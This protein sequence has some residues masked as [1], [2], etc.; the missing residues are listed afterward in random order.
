MDIQV[1]IRFAQENDGELP[2]A[3]AVLRY[4]A[5]INTEASRDEF[6][7]ACVACGYKANSSANRF[8]ESRN[9]DRTN[10]GHVFDRDGRL[11]QERNL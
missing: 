11:I 5:A 4:V 10:Y 3:A 1:D 2:T 9:F 7:A 8:R 6:V